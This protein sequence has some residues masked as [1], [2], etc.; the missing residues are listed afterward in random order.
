KTSGCS[1]VYCLVVW[2]S[3]RRSRTIACDSCVSPVN[4]HNRLLRKLKLWLLTPICPKNLRL[5]FT[6][7]ICLHYLLP[8]FSSVELTSV[9]VFLIQS[10]LR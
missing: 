4:C 9:L 5:T 7:K 6:Q 3:V 2:R 8:F 10:K 1:H